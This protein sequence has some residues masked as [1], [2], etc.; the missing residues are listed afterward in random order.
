MKSKRQILVTY[1]LLIAGVA[2]GYS[3]IDLYFTAKYKSNYYP[4]DSIIIENTNTGSK[5]IKYYPDTLLQ[6]IITKIDDL[7]NPNE[8]KLLLNQNYPNPFENKTNFDIY[9]PQNDLLAI[10]IYNI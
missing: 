6:L 1:C 4:L 7:N 3:Q 5:V 2:C 10:N 9:L 8:H